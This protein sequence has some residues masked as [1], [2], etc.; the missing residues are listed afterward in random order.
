MGYFSILRLGQFPFNPRLIPYFHIYMLNFAS[1]SSTWRR[2]GPQ[3]S[4]VL[5]ADRST[6]TTTGVCWWDSGTTTQMGSTRA[7]GSAA[8]TF[9]GSGKRAAPSATASVGSLLQS[10]AQVGAAVKVCCCFSNRQ[11]ACALHPSCRLIW[12]KFRL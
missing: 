10:P 11:R 8:R 2:G 12:P 4:P 9:C 6:V 1:A 3:V 7:R 5:S